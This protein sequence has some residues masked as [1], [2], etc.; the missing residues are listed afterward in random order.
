MIVWPFSYLS[1]KKAFF[2]ELSQTLLFFE[3][4]LEIYA[5]NMLVLFE[6]ELLSSIRICC[7]KNRNNEQKFMYKDVHHGIIYK[8]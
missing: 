5:I 2:N 6:L 1:S 8:I 7:K 3:C 4:N